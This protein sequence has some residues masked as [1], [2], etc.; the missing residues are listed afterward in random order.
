MRASHRPPTQAVG[1]APCHDGMA[2]PMPESMTQRVQ[3][4]GGKPFIVDQ[5]GERV[6]VTD[7]HGT[8]AHFEMS[9]EPPAGARMK[10]GPPMRARIPSAVYL[11]LAVVFAGVTWLAYN[12]PSGSTLFTWAVEGDRI[13]PLSVSVVAVVVLVSALATV[14]RTQ[15]RG[16]VVT[17]DWIESRSLL[18]FGIP[19]A[20]RWAWA[21]VTR[22][23]V[24]GER[25]GLQF[26]DGG[27]ER[28]PEVADG[29]GLAQ[30]MMHHAGKHKIDVSVLRPDIG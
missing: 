2:S 30:L 29:K 6:S 23:V 5:E 14:I 8:I 17:D 11:V 3:R 15:M 20:R 13:R 26:Y 28:L 9:Y 12:S 25:T 21:Q 16:V 1:E 19:R 10:F 4:D 18:A 24:D 27:F 22:I 7:A